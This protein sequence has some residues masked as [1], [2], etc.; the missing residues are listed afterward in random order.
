MAGVRPV[1]GGESEDPEE[2]KKSKRGTSVVA[3]NPKTTQR[4]SPWS[5]A[6]KPTRSVLAAGASLARSWQGT[7]RGK[8]LPMREGGCGER[9]TPERKQT[10]TWLR[11]EISPRSEKRRK[12][13]RG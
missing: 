10:W 4:D 7:A 2:E 8:L 9:E 12:P 1:R 13:P 3:A 11:D 5:K 6:S